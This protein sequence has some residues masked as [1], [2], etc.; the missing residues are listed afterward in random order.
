MGNWVKDKWHLSILVLTPACKSA[1][2]SKSLRKENFT[3]YMRSWY[4]TLTVDQ[5]DLGELK[6]LYFSVLQV[7]MIFSQ[8]GIKV[9]VTVD[10]DTSLWCFV[11]PVY[12]DGYARIIMSLEL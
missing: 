6:N 1:V 11:S 2:T 4:S 10:P 5:I 7:I 12:G 3:K 9:N 8:V